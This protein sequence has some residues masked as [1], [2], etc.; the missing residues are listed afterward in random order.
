[1]VPYFQANPGI[2]AADAAADLGV[3][4]KQ[5]LSDLNQLWMCG[6]PGYGPGDLIDL[7]FSGDSI[8][9]TFSAGIDRP[10]R[11]TSIEATGLLMAL[12]SLADMPGM[13]DPTAAQ[14][15]IAKIESA[16]GVAAARNRPDR[17]RGRRDRPS[18]GPE[19]RHRAGR[20]RRWAR[21]A[22]GLLLGEPRRR[23][24][25]RRRPDPDSR[26]RRA[27]LPAGVV[28]AGGGGAAVPLR[29]DRRSHRARR[30]RQPARRRA[31][32]GP[33]AGTVQ[34]R[35]RAAAGAAADRRDRD[36]DA[37]PVPDD[38]RR[39]GSDGWSRLA[40]RGDDDGSPASNG[41]PD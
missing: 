3:T 22:A 24:G 8:E 10:L 20:A 33:R 30:A 17:I 36:L 37:R 6:L 38:S 9:V 29:P 1:M 7:R 15:A 12:R 21:A 25:P 4:Q 34:R 14:G 2:S 11:L 26:D 23:L 5:L 31:G 32:R 35:P 18:R 19:R 13:V 39:A 28:S 27:Q 16:A 41:W 40:C